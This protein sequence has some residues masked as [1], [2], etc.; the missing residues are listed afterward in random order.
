MLFSIVLF[1][2]CSLAPFT[3]TKTARSLGKGTW[4]IDAGISPAYSFSAS[5]GLSHKFDLGLTIEG[6]VGAPV[7]ALNGKYAFINKQNEGFSL[8]G[9][10]GAFSGAGA[11]SYGYYLGPVFSYKVKWFEPYLVARY[12]WVK[13]KGVDLSTDDTDDLFV[14]LL[15]F[16]DTD[17][18]YMQY[19]FGIN[20]WFSQT[21]GLNL[22]LKVI[23]FFGND[24]E[25]DDQSGVA[26]PG[27]ALLL[28]F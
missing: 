19:T 18:S 26:T 12:N 7:F 23:T 8:S 2:S 4:E 24:V 3:S 1:S 22:N 5:R 28:R 13:W 21:F 20:F 15:D 6:Q 10:G 16:D 9:F 25:A 17:I 11:D 27:V 14:D